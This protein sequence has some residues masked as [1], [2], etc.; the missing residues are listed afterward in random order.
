LPSLL[1]QLRT[2]CPRDSIIYS[3]LG[4]PTSKIDQESVPPGGSMFSIEGL[5]F[6]MTPVYVKLTKQHEEIWK[7]LG[8]D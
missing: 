7:F 2:T 1:K 8:K 3:E 6:Q 5:S 4:P